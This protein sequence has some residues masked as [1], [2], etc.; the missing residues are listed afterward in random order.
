MDFFHQ[1]NG[2]LPS[3]SAI[4]RLVKR[5]SRDIKRTRQRLLANKT[6]FHVRS[7]TNMMFHLSEKPGLLRK[8]FSGQEGLSEI[9][10]S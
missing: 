3:R 7:Y 8:D 2:I 6:F 4:F 1:N 5:F 10:L 9:Q